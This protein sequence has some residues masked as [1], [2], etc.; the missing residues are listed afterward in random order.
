MTNYTVQ[1]KLAEDRPLLARVA[2]CAAGQ[3]LINPFGWATEYGWQLAVQPGWAEAAEAKGSEGVTDAMIRNGVAAVL[4]AYPPPDH[5]E[6][7]PN[8]SPA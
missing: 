8:E 3:G 1:A 7:D 2:A 6:P 4:A 5:R